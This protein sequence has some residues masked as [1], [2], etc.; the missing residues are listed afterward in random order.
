MLSPL[1]DLPV[2]RRSVIIL[3]KEE[4]EA[5][6]GSKPETDIEKVLKRRIEK[7]N[8]PFKEIEQERSLFGD[9]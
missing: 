6:F 7:M 1:W 9:Y 5:I 4:I 2:A 3:N 8:A